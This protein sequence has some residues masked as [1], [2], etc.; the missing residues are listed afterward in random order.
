MRRKRERRGRGGRLRGAERGRRRGRGD[1]TVAF[2]MKR[3]AVLLG[4]LGG[5]LAVGMLWSSITRTER[6]AR[7]TVAPVDVKVGPS[8]TRRALPE[9]TPPDVAE[10]PVAA[11]AHLALRARGVVRH[12]GS[13]VPGAV[14]QC[15]ALGTI[16]E[17]AS[18]EDGTFVYERLPPA[19]E[20]EFRAA[21]ESG[22][23]SVTVLHS[24]VANGPVSL[25]L[26]PVYYERLRFLDEAGE[27]VPI[28]G[29]GLYGLVTS[30]TVYRS[31]F[32]LGDLLEPQPLPKGFVPP[33]EVPSN[34]IV[35]VGPLQA[36]PRT[37]RVRGYKALEVPVE[38]WPLDRWPEAR[39][40][41]LERDHRE[42]RDV[43]YR[44]RLPE[45]HVPHSWAP[46][47]FQPFCLGVTTEGDPTRWITTSAPEVRVPPGASL[48]LGVWPHGDVEFDI[49][50]ATDGP[51]LQPAYPEYAFLDLHFP[52]SHP[53]VEGTLGF[54]RITSSSPP[55]YLIGFLVE[56][57]H[58][59]FAYVPVGEYSVTIGW[60]TLGD[61]D[62][63][64]D[65]QGALDLLANPHLANKPPD[66][67][68]RR[69]VRLEAGH[70]VHV[71]EADG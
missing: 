3:T 33:D 25:D 60:S 50:S 46:G 23:A 9:S 29:A 69:T 67:E 39:S 71:A 37:V 32:H 12:G 51:E 35:C 11:W 24:A 20:Y 16:H 4:V 10:A 44:L 38:P 21:A 13:P 70:N 34:E 6:R 62:T 66:W 30:P 18:A 17:T 68:L 28:A 7:E 57:G 1:V 42:E 59:R 40:V 45:Q 61:E 49:A 22:C 63:P 55:L 19:L 41:V 43:H 2:R 31:V 27:P 53:D 14:V 65:R 52:A 26:V 36:R 5:I 47:S 64:I 8:P 54:A 56:P 58:A 48:R 15:K